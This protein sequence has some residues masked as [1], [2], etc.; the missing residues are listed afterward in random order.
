MNAI[1][2]FFRSDLSMPPKSAWLCAL[3]GAA[4][5]AIGMPIEWR[6]ASTVTGVPSYWALISTAVGLVSCAY[7]VARRTKPNVNEA[8]VVYAFNMLAISGTFLLTNYYYIAGLHLWVPFQ[9]AKLGSVISV[10]IAPSF[11]LGTI[12]VF[13]FAGATLIQYFLF[14]SYTQSRV[15][16]G[17][18][19]VT[20]AFGVASLMALVY[21]FS[22]IWLERRVIEAETESQS[23]KKMALAF[24]SLRDLMNTPLQNLEFSLG[25]IRTKKMADSELCSQMERAIHK[26]RGVNEILM[27]HERELEW[28]RTES[29]DPKKQLDAVLGKKV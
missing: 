19:W 7:L 16:F 22:R 2:R 17:E 28:N 25:I 23:M 6:L 4:L 21:R 10:L 9:G 3:S 26:L 5:N 27:K 24:L 14:S 13:M 20:A 29:F 11:L 1:I 12:G 15:A 8:F 18:P